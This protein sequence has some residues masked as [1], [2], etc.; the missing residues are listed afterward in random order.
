MYIKVVFSQKSIIEIERSLFE[1]L[2]HNNPGNED[3]IYSEAI[4]KLRIS[5][6]DLKNVATKYEVPYSLFFAPSPMIDIQIKEYEKIILDKLPSKKSGEIFF[7]SRSK[8]LDL[9]I[10]R[11]IPLIVKDISRKQTLL[12]N[13]NPTATKMLFTY[14]KNLS[15]KARYIVKLFQINLKEIKS[16]ETALRYLISKIEDHDIFV[17]VSSYNYMPQRILKN[18]EF[19]GFYIKDNYFPFIFINTKDDPASE[20]NIMET[21]GRQILTLV[22]LL[23]SIYENNH[24]GKKRVTNNFLYDLAGEILLPYIEL[25]NYKISTYSDLILVSDI[26]KITPS[27][28]LERIKKTIDKGLFILL[29]DEI[30]KNRKNKTSIG[31]S[32]KGDTS[33][34]FLKYNGQHFSEIIVKNYISN[35]IAESQAKNILFRKKKVTKKTWDSYCKRLNL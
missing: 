24:S 6:T 27:F 5:F 26:Y 34:Q 23:C 19:S 22:Y 18:V 33:K 2:F 17:S 21:E 30:I 31:R 11:N 1:K 32:I 35:N 4:N 16:K 3:G 14:H 8:K 15:D 7:Y 20:S 13:M 28:L 10:K 29:R 25:K 12:K 9:D